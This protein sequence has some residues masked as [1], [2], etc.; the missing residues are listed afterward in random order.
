MLP[1]S[2]SQLRESSEAPEGGWPH[3][4]ANVGESGSSPQIGSKRGCPWSRYFPNV[5]FPSIAATAHGTGWGLKG[6]PGSHS[7]I[8][9]EET[10]AGIMEDIADTAGPRCAEG[11]GVSCSLFRGRQLSEL[12]RSGKPSLKGERRRK[13]SEGEAFKLVLEQL[14]AHVAMQKES[15]EGLLRDQGH[16]G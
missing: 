1:P 16:S 8:R 7:L 5:L 6:K 2:P 11:W 9:G 4:P 10:C 15:E 12:Q 14:L 13:R 3:S